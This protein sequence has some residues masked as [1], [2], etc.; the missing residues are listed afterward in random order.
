VVSYRLRIVRFW[1]VRFANV[2]VSYN[3]SLNVPPPRVIQLFHCK[4]RDD[5][6]LN[7]CYPQSVQLCE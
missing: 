1:R 6:Q 3:P 7:Y 2:T 4:Q 5:S